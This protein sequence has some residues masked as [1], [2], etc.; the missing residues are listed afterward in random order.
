M[1]KLQINFINE[2]GPRPFFLQHR[3]SSI[4]SKYRNFMRESF[5]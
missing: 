2:R 4:P 3:M 1:G 5:G